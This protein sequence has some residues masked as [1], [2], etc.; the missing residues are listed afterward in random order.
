MKKYIFILVVAATNLFQSISAVTL[1]EFKTVLQS[2]K[3]NQLYANLYNGL[4]NRVDSD[5]YLP[6][7]VVDESKGMYAR[8]ASAYV[9]MLIETEHFEEAEKTLQFVLDAITLHDM[10]R[11]PRA[12]GKTEILDDRHQIDAQAQFILAWARLATARGNTEFVNQTWTQASK[13]MDRTCSRTF[14]QYGGWSIEPGL[15]KNIA[16]EHTKENRMWDCWDLLSQSFIGAALTEMVQVAGNRNE[17]SKANAWNNKL[18]ILKNG[19]KN[20]LIVTKAGKSVYTE[21]FLPKNGNGGI[22]YGGM[23]WINF[24]P[25]AAK[26]VPDTEVMK[27]TIDYLETNYLQTYNGIKWLSEDIYPDGKFSNEI[28]GKGIAWQ[29][30]YAVSQQ[31]YARALE[32]LDLMTIINKGLFT[33]FAWLEGDGYTRKDKIAQSDVERMAS[34]AWKSNDDISSEQM[35]WWCWAMARARRIC[36]LAVIPE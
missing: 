3:V 11:I 18:N 25:V 13:L 33:D 22:A 32:I 7:S 26:F 31:N 4:L 23:S 29:F 36:Q 6:E 12:F 2:E 14:F 28:I 35:A 5:G 1:E 8:T 16:F 10:E 27:N 9:Y 21:M 24:A 19:I 34:A 20:R 17:T 30:E 15:I